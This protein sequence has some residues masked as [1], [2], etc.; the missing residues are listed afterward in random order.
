MAKTNLNKLSG[1]RKANPIK[2][3]TDDQ[4]ISMVVFECLLNND[5]DGAM[6]MI[7]IYLDAMNKAN[8][9]RKTKLPKSTIEE[10]RKL[11]TAE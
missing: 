2:D 5:P 1:L 4:Q 7:A 6:E 3:L 9:R 11:K 8:L 10:F